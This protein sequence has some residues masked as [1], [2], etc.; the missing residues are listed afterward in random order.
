MPLTSTSKNPSLLLADD[1]VA[2]CLAMTW[3]LQGHGFRVAIAHDADTALKQAQHDIP[4][5]A[6]LD[7]KMPGKSGLTLLP[8]LKALKADMRILILTGYASITTAVEAIK[9]GA[10]HYLAKPVDAEDVMYA[11]NKTSGDPNM[12]PGANTLSA[13]D[14]EW[15]HLQKVLKDNHGNIS[16]TARQ[17]NIDR[18]T[19]QR[20]LVRHRTR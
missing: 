13:A 11:F 10:T 18:R 17:L 3:A 6:V 7:L 14:F 1:D 2:F 8:N 19:L 4:D 20:K 5:Y 9:L 16:A 12:V 15:E